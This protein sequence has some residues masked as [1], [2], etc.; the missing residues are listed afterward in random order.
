MRDLDVSQASPSTILL[1]DVGALATS[2]FL[3]YTLRGSFGYALQPS[4]FYL[5]FIG[6]ALCAFVI[7]GTLFSL[8]TNRKNIL[9][10][11][12]L[13]DFLRTYALWGAFIITWPFLIKTDYSRTVVLF[14]V[15]ISFFMLYGGR[16]LLAFVTRMSG[17]SDAEVTRAVRGILTLI[18]VTPDPIALLEDVRISRSL[19]PMDRLAKR[20]LDIV[21]ASVGCVILLLV[22]PVIAW[23]I[24][25]E[26][27]GPIFFVRERVGRDGKIFKMFKFRTMY[28]HEKRN[29]PPR[30]SD[31]PRITPFGRILRRYSID[32]LPQVINVLRG[33]MSLVGP[34]P[35][36]PAL[37]EKYEPW[38]RARLRTLPGLTGLWQILGRKDLPLNE[39]LEYDLYYVFN[40]S[41]F[42]DCAIILKTIPHLV[43]PK[44]AY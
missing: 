8:Y 14:F 3:A 18:R 29:S 17:S 27:P 26:S 38:Q 31:D 20:S 30:S 6:S 10:L 36:L 37:V 9:S 12:Y 40:Q 21:G 25:R 11:S 22:I 43:L 15:V 42:L 24:R 39:N 23:R 28:L 2:F 41:F 33:D 44:G 19:R 4:S 1:F 34:R 16:I 13:S 7:L 35:E 32:E 5:L